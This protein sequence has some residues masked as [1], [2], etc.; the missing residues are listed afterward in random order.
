M[1]TGGSCNSGRGC[2]VVAVAAATGKQ[3]LYHPAWQGAGWG[4]KYPNLFLFLSPVSYSIH[5]AWTRLEAAT[6]QMGS[7]ETNEESPAQKLKLFCKQLSGDLEDIWVTQTHARAIFCSLS[8]SST[9]LCLPSSGS[10]SPFVMQNC[11][12]PTFIHLDN[13]SCMSSVSGQ[14]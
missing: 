1:K 6:L 13:K 12:P 3:L 4:K 9:S 2:L 14:S 11:L 5:I 8:L 10:R 7:G